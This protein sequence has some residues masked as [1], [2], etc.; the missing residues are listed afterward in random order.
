MQDKEV[1]IEYLKS[2][3]IDENEI[4]LKGFV[5]SSGELINLRLIES[6]LVVTDDS[7][8]FGWKS[9]FKEAQEYAIK[10]K[11]GIWDKDLGSIC[12]TLPC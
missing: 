1:E 12:G 4:F 11:L 3:N 2:N 10:L 7:F 8:E 6:G 9:R 5:F